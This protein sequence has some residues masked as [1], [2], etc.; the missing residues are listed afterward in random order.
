M[1]KGRKISINDCKVWFKT[2]AKS[3]VRKPIGQNDFVVLLRAAAEAGPPQAFRS[4]SSL[5]FAS[6]PPLRASPLKDNR[7]LQRSLY[8]LA[9]DL[10]V[11]RITSEFCAF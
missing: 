7:I 6:V 2:A 11:C 5:L 3:G 4:Q 10:E 9:S 1:K 8:V